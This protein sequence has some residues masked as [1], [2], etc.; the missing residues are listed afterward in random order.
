M[1]KIILMAVLAFFYFSLYGASSVFSVIAPTW[2]KV[3]VPQ[4]DG[5]N[6]RKYASSTAPKLMY[7]EMNIEFYDTPVIY[8]A[9]WVTKPT[10]YMVAIPFDSPMPIVGEK[11]GWYEVLNCGPSYKENGWV[12]A[13]YAKMEN[14]EKITATNLPKERLGWINRGED[15][16]YMVDLVYNE[17]EGSAE[18]RIG[19][20]IDGVVVVPY[21]LNCPSAVMETDSKPQIRKM[22][23]YYEFVFNQ[24]CSSPDYEYDPLASNLSKELLEEI[25]KYSE[26]ATENV[27]Y[28][29]VNGEIYYI[30]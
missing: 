14:I 6:I 9:K 7:D 26:P 22:N 23:G 27:Y 2:D 20:L 25:I 29:M 28:V 16:I 11:N 17:M 3:A 30:P 19:R 12:N 24:S 5:I 4:T 21:V 15:G 13:K 10:K 1:K 18:F 8:Y